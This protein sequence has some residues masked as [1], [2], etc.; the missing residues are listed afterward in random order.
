[1]EKLF[2]FKP[3]KST[4]FCAFGFC[5][6]KLYVCLNIDLHTSVIVQNTHTRASLNL[7][8]IRGG[9]VQSKAKPHHISVMHF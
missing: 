7:S 9:L 8:T 1:M 4:A 3:V 6:L 2:V 5:K